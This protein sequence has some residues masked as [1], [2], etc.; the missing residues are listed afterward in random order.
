MMGVNRGQ[1]KSIGMGRVFG[2]GSIRK[3]KRKGVLNRGLF[4]MDHHIPQIDNGEGLAATLGT[5]IAKYNGIAYT[6]TKKAYL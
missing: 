2:D 4:D 3:K 1:T 6:K 5:G